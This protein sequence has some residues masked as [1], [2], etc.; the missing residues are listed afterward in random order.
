VDFWEFQASQGYTVSGSMSK[1]A[2][3]GSV[4]LK[5]TMG[6]LRQEDI[7]LEVSTNHTVR[8]CLVGLERWFSEWLRALAALP[9]VLSSTPSTHMVAPNHL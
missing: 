6:R 3:H 9:E 2:G 5:P 4:H 1:N 7:E 8:V